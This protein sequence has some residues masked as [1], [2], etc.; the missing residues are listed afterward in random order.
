MPQNATLRSGLDLV[1]AAIAAGTLLIAVLTYGLIAQ[2][3]STPGALPDPAG[4]VFDYKEDPWAAS[5]GFLSIPSARALVSRPRWDKISNASLNSSPD[6]AVSLAIVGLPVD[7]DHIMLMD[8]RTDTHCLARQS[9]TE[10]S[11]A[12]CVKKSSEYT[13]LRSSKEYDLCGFT[14]DCWH[15]TAAALLASGNAMNEKLFSF[16]TIAALPFKD[17]TKHD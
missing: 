13:L 15:S 17:G 1:A 6:Q 10:Q 12:L 14:D 11:V 5:T 16:N 2:D 8:N 7:L 4:T 9:A 3:G